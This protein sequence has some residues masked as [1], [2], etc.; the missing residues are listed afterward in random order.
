MV[1]GKREN[2]ALTA[3]WTRQGAA[4]SGT[5]FAYLWELRREGIWQDCQ[6]F[7]RRKEACYE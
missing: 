1:L 2:S 5:R 7:E 4:I 6:G 3:I